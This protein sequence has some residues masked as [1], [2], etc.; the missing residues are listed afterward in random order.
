MDCEPET[1]IARVMVRA[2]WP[3]EAVE[4]V[5]AQQARR[6]IRRAM[7]HHIILNEGLSLV[8]LRTEVNKLCRLWNNHA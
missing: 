2:G 8:E 5:L 4:Q 7:A 3:R 6:E 1:Q